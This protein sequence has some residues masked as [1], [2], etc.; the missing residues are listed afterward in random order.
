MIHEA[1]HRP[2]PV[3]L[4]ADRRITRRVKRLAATSSVAL[5]LIWALAVTTLEAPAPVDAALAA[6]WS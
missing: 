4:T 1:L 3:E 6:G 2:I 5:G